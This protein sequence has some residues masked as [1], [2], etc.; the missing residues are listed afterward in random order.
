MKKLSLT[1]KTAV[2]IAV[3]AAL[4]LHL[5]TIASQQLQPSGQVGRA[6]QVLFQLETTLNYLSITE[7]NE[8]GYLASGNPEILPRFEKSKARTLYELKRLKDLLS[9][10]GPQT[11][12]M[13]FAHLSAQVDERLRLADQSIQSMQVSGTEAAWQTIVSG[14]EQ[15]ISEAIRNITN[16]IRSSASQTVIARDQQLGVANRDTLFGIWAIML[17]AF[18]MLLLLLAFVRRYEMERRYSEQALAEREARMRAVVDTAPDGIVTV[19]ESGTVETAN[20]AMQLMFQYGADELRGMN[21]KQLMPDFFGDEREH[22]KGTS[23]LRAGERRTFGIG[24]EVEGKRSDGSTVPVELALSLLNLGEREIYTGIV[25]NITER[26]EAERRVSEFYSIVSH[27]LRTPLTS[28]RTA[29]GLFESGVAGE[30]SV[31]ASRLVEIARAECDRLIRLINDILDIRKIEEGKLTLNPQAIPAQRLAEITVTGIRGLAEEAGVQLV[32]DVSYHGEV[33]CDQDRIV[34]VITNLLSNAIKF[35]RQGDTVTLRAEER[36]AGEIRFSVI[37]HGPGIAQEELPK[38]FQK[39]QQL[40]S[41]DTRQKGGTGL[42]LAI[43]KAIVKE[44][45]GTIGVDTEKNKGATFWFEL[46]RES[47]LEPGSAADKPLRKPVLLIDDDDRTYTPLKGLLSGDGR[48]LIRAA[49]ATQARKAIEE[50][51]PSLLLF[52]LQLSEGGGVSLSD[53]LNSLS[54]HTPMLIF[55]GRQPENQSFSA[56][57]ISYIAE[58]KIAVSTLASMLDTS[59]NEKPRVLYA[60]AADLEEE[61]AR[62]KKDKAPLFSAGEFDTEILSASNSAW[63]K[64]YS[65]ILMDADVS[66]KTC[67]DIIQ[68]LREHVGVPLILLTDGPLQQTSVDRL[69]LAFSQQSSKMQMNEG[70]F[71]DC[72]RRLI[73]NLLPQSEVMLQRNSHSRLSPVSAEQ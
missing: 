69:I 28:I 42:G 24:K 12:E 52:T 58:K 48:D 11:D 7:S 71:L 8:L 40:D 10:S 66:D 64:N 73:D 43:S 60:P 68:K 46:R 1:T 14:Q 22:R 44:H 36:D 5:G 19:D 63:S 37:D 55:S 57:V 41:S 39:F 35:S 27:E 2:A 13:M 6:H 65:A 56:P 21:V 59:S 26:K 53:C 34:Q 25:R 49:T 29:I 38:L 15:R 33:Y 9:G 30:L 18:V 4:L 51:N 62:Q 67:F 70:E 32:S 23:V 3:T 54:R 45:G 20:A 72:I 17:L 31:R 61:V 16:S 47:T 50:Q